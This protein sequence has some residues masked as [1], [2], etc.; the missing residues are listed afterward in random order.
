MRIPGGLMEGLEGVTFNDEH[1]LSRKVGALIGYLE[2]L[3][4]YYDGY[5]GNRPFSKNNIPQEEAKRFYKLVVEWY[6]KEYTE[7]EKREDRAVDGSRP[8]GGIIY[9]LMDNLRQT[10]LTEY[11]LPRTEKASLEDFR[12]WLYRYTKK[13]GEQA[14]KKFRY[15]EREFLEVYRPFNHPIFEGRVF[16]D[17]RVARKNLLLISGCGANAI[18]VITPEGVEV[19]MAYPEAN[20]HD[21]IYNT[22]MAPE[23]WFGSIDIPREISREVKGLGKQI[24]IQLGQTI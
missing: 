14:I 8:E 2:Q 6:E 9:K 3:N 12:D 7:E 16:S 18:N 20:S 13:Y 1:D 24:E 21:K 4:K 15:P 11:F 23:K 5:Y 22:E 17:L 19:K 10:W